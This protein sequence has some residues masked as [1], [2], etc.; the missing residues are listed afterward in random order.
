MST[1]TVNRPMEQAFALWEKKSDKGTNY[2]SGQD[3]VVA[4]Y[5]NRKKSLRDPDIIVYQNINENQRIT[6]CH[7][8]ANTSSKGGK[9]LTGSID[10]RKVVGFFNEKHEVKQPYISVYYQDT[11]APAAEQVPMTDVTDNDELPF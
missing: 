1:A 2:L 8:W 5:N 9:Y 10:G 3:G 11:E 6:L 4:F 7:L